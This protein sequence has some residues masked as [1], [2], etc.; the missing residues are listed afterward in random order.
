MTQ[1]NRHLPGRQH[2]RANKRFDAVAWAAR[3]ARWPRLAQ[4]NAERD[5]AKTLDSQ[6]PSEYPPAS[7][8]DRWKR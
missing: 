1:R 6:K 8:W 4:R 7:Y 5:Q 3:K 2:R